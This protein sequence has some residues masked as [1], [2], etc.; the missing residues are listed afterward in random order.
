VR[1]RRLP[2]DHVLLEVVGEVDLLTAPRLLEAAS[3]ELHAGC[4]A[5]VL[6]LAGVGFCSVRGL[7]T[8]VEIRRLAD[9]H[10]ARVRVD[11]VSP[12]VRRV[13]DLVRAREVV[14]GPTA[15]GRRDG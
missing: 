8:L 7:G 1:Q 11:R 3:V 2:P 12:T 5:L 14:D 13:A 15:P 4:R 9:R 10:D 6:D